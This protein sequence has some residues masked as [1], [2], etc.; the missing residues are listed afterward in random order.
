MSDWKM[1]YESEEVNPAGT[2]G[3]DF[4]EFAAKDATALRDLFARLGFIK[5]AKHNSKDVE[6]WQQGTIK[7]V[8][9]AEADSFC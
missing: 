4:L 3:F 7:F 6:L 2:K 8:I 5:V 9:N 1:F